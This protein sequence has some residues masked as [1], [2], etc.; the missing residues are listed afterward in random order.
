M[1]ASMLVQAQLV[2]PVE[3]A[4]PD[5]FAAV[6]QRILAGLPHTIGLPG[7]AR[8]LLALPTG[9]AAQWRALDPDRLI[10]SSTLEYAAQPEAA[11]EAVPEFRG[12]PLRLLLQRGGRTVAALP[13][14]AGLRTYVEEFDAGDRVTLEVVVASWELHA[15]DV[16]GPGD[17]GS[18]ISLG[19]R[20][21][22]E[23]VAHFS[24]APP[25]PKLVPRLPPEERTQSSTGSSS[26]YY[27]YTVEEMREI[28]FTIHRDSRKRRTRR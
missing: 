25:N 15:G 9:L 12:L 28:D 18:R 24:P 13:L 1:A 10:S 5:G 2:P 16:V 26:G 19:W 14:V 4:I 23:P 6:E 20:S 21:A 27:G 17:F 22:S 7:D 11:T 8:L 3:P